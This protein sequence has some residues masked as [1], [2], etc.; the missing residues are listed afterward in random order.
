MPEQ[1]KNEVKN[2]EPTE[3]SRLMQTN[4]PKEYECKKS[5][6]VPGFPDMPS[7]DYFKK[8]PEEK[9]E[10]IEAQKKK[11]E[12]EANEKKESDE[13]TAKENHLTAED[14]YN[15]AIREKDVAINLL[16]TKTKNN[17]TELLRVYKEKLSGLVPKDCVDKKVPQDKLAICVA[18]L[19]KLLADVEINYL[20]KS[21]EIEEKFVDA[22]NAWKKAG[23]VIKLTVCE[24]ELT[25]TVAFEK[26]EVD[27]RN[28]ISELLKQF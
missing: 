26:A 22:E 28:K 20:K 10:L 25:R 6:S 13:A 12:N 16:E 5:P 21:K 8:I 1:K 9:L 18:E 11:A 23:V 15:K 24:I 27:R 17:K 14:A 7:D 3:E 19:N 4:E 2:V